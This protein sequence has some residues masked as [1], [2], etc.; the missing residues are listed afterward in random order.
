MKIAHE[1]KKRNHSD[2]LEKTPSRT[3]VLIACL[4]P[5]FIV[6]R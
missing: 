6:T 4:L 1:N 3:F 5:Y 2:E